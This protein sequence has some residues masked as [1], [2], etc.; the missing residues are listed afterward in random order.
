MLAGVNDSRAD[1]LRLGEIARAMPSKV[2]LIPYN[3]VPQLDWQR[4][5]EAVVPRFVDIL[6][7]RAPSVTVRRSQ[8]RDVWAACGQL[9]S[10]PTPPSA[11]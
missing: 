9:G 11:R 8:G 5:D 3:P 7:P 4:P 1:A 6:L 10:R 2:N